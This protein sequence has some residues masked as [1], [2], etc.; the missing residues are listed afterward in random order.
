MLTVKQYINIID[1]N[2]YIIGLYSGIRTKYI[3][4]KDMYNYYSK[5]I[6]NAEK[7]NT[8]IINRFFREKTKVLK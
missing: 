6:Q 3:N 2:S 1:Q 5:I 8:K 7:R 4:D